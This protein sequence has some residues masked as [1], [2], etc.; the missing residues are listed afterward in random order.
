MSTFYERLKVEKTELDEKLT[1][2][3]AFIQSDKFKEVDPEQKPL[4]QTQAGVMK[5]YS[6]I[7]EKRLKLLEK[8]A[9]KVIDE[10]LKKSD[11]KE[12]KT[13]A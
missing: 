1:K 8:K 5:T 9:A 3:N 11:S 12:E 13:K 4:L 6:Q 7:L 2:L 10:N